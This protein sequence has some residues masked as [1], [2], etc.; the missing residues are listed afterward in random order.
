MHTSFSFTSICWKD[1]TNELADPNVRGEP[2]ASRPAVVDAAAVDDLE[3]KSKSE[4]TL[5]STSATDDPAAGVE[6]EFDRSD[7]ANTGANSVDGGSV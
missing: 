6:A 7:D 5:E 4:L 2:D 1:A 3:P